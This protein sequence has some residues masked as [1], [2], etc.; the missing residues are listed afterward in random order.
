MNDCRSDLNSFSLTD[1]A[2]NNFY[3]CFYLAKAKP[4]LLTDE[5]LSIKNNEAEIAEKL[6]TNSEQLQ[7]LAYKQIVNLYL[8]N[9]VETFE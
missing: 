7:T 1:F 8:P 3:N 6:R 9:E 2:L 5:Q 4:I